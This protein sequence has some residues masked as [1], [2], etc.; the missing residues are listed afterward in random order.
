M[1]L[2]NLKYFL[3]VVQQSS[4]TRA[5][6]KLHITQQALSAQIAKLENELQVK[7]FE[8]KPELSLTYAGQ[9]VADYARKML[10]MQQQLDD[11]LKG[12]AAQQRGYLRIG[13]SHT[14]GQVILPLI[15]PNFHKLYP[16][17]E[18][19]ILEASTSELEE[20][21]KNGN[22]DLLIG[23]KPFKLEGV[24]SKELIKDKL[25][26]IIADSLLKE[27]YPNNYKEMLGNYNKSL[28]ITIFKDL[29]FIS[30]KKGERIREALEQEFMNKDIKPN[31]YLETR[32]AQT[33]FALATKGMGITIYPDMYL[34]SDTALH[35]VNETHILP[36][37][38]SGLTDTIAIGYYGSRYLSRI[39]KNF[40]QLSVKTFKEIENN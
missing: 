2:T 11:E 29:P 37:D 9:K 24:V 33:A 12:V 18:L 25:D 14:R 27:Y 34:L 35:N 19:S 36:F 32:N 3:A 5:A 21:L 31:V 13:I 22:I 23:F 6:S 10:D 28:D 38:S 15:L 20:A 39:A 26:L 1:N 8:R 7:L 30:L 17:I 16:L 40:I 4:I